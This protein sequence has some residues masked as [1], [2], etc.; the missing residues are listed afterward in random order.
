MWNEKGNP[1]SIWWWARAYW[2]YDTAD[3]GSVAETKTQIWQGLKSSQPGRARA[4]ETS[5]FTFQVHL[6]QSIAQPE[7][8]IYPSG[9]GT[10]GGGKGYYW[11]PKDGYS[12]DTIYAYAC[13]LPK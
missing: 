3:G 8:R 9:M 6:Q 4:G 5:D 7:S 12:L 10:A 2:C 1:Y 13:P 11:K